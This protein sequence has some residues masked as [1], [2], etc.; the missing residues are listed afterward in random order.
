M[1]AFFWIFAVTITGAAAL[2]ITRRSGVAAALWAAVAFVG[3]A[4]IFILL[5]AYFLAVVEVLVY[6]GAIMVLFLFVIMLLNLRDEDVRVMTGPRLH[7]VGAL[8]A[9]GFLGGLVWTVRRAGLFDVPIDVGPRAGETGNV[10]EPLFLHYLLPFEMASFL[11]LA[12]IVGAV[13]IT[14]RRLR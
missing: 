7:V 10:A 11:L 8:L 6:A 5:H 3:I 2:A 13:L 14:K 4:G 9:A 12:A 1:T